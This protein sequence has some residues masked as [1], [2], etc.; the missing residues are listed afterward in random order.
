MALFGRRERDEKRPPNPFL[1]PRDDGLEA[2]PT[3]D[4]PPAEPDHNQVPSPAFVEP[5]D[6]TGGPANGSS[7]RAHGHAGRPAMGENK[8]THRVGISVNSKELELLKLC[9]AQ[10]G[11]KSVA[12][13]VRDRILNS[14]AI[15]ALSYR[16]YG[17]ELPQLRGALNKVGN[18][19]N[20]IARALNVAERGGPDAPSTDEVLAAVDAVRAEIGEIRAWTRRQ[21]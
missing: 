16:G 9:A 1:R 12:R 15:E 5:T 14:L 11:N 2:V 19:L 3:A 13:W 10:D 18:N 8:R 4:V 21:S 20:Q 17:S 7:A 6:A